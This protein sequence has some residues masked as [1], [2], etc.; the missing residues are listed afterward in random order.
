MVF[1]IRK[2]TITIMFLLLLF[3]E[4]LYAR[5]HHFSYYSD[6]PEIFLNVIENYRS[7]QPEACKQENGII[8]GGIVTHHFLASRLMVDFFECLASQAEPERIILIGPDHFA[9]GVYPITVSALPW[10]TPFGELPADES[11]VSRIKELLN[12]SDD[13]EA[14]SGE[15]SIGIIVPFIRYYFPRS[16]II[17]I[18]IQ[19]QISMYTLVELK[20]I[21]SQLLNDHKTLVLLS[22]DFSH[23]QT[24]EEADQRDENSRDA[25]LQ[26][27]CKR[28]SELDIDCRHGL[29]LL[30]ATLKE[31]KT[32]NIYFRQHTNSAKI[33]G[34]KNL[35]DITSYY[36]IFF[37]KQDLS[38]QNDRG[39]KKDE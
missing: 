18:I 1:K 33:T 39:E 25:I 27:D 7:S 17:P 29:F 19:G 30:M 22:M 28:I 8:R 32:M 36:T 5:D 38:K 26:L 23:N 10:K 9:K 2:L 20:Q 31:L 16:K 3:T 21:I 14:F 4:S 37:Y 35:K 11:I 34:L 12:L 6:M 15:H 24:S 13:V